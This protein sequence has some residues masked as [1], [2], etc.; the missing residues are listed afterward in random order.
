MYINPRSL[1]LDR[2]QCR[3]L[4]WAFVEDFAQLSN[5]HW[6]IQ[7]MAVL[8]WRLLTINRFKPIH[9][10]IIGNNVTADR[11]LVFLGYQQ[12]CDRLVV[13]Q[14]GEFAYSH[15]NVSISA[16]AGKYQNLDKNKKVNNYLKIF[17]FAIEWRHCE[18]YTPWPWSTFSWSN[19]SN[20][21]ISKMVRSTTKMRDTDFKD[22]DICHR[23]ALLQK[24][25]SVTLTF[26]KVKYCKCLYL[27]N[28]ESSKMLDTDFIDFDIFHRMTPFQKKYS[29]TL[30]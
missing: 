20:V 6:Y 12:T 19:I 29:S 17:I 10:G 26:F 3:L 2:L 7:S 23:M 28:G 9:V 14:I 13:R 11:C 27:W 21:N 5:R 25:Y 8:C 15:G 1:S 18:F 24:M 22:F 16:Y 30:T 4:S